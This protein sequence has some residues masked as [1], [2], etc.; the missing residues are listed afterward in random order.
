M[1]YHIN[2]GKKTLR[3]LKVPWSNNTGLIIDEL[4]R[5]GIL[6]QKRKPWPDG[7]KVR[8]YWVN[9]T[10]DWSVGFAQ[11]D[12]YRA[13]LAVLVPVEF[14]KRFGAYLEKKTQTKMK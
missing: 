8:Q 5:M 11:T 2:L 4:I 6:A 13:F 14:R 3:W 9:F 12:F 10:F 1:P 7:H